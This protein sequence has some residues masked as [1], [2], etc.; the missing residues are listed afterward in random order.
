MDTFQHR[1]QNHL[2]LMFLGTEV[3]PPDAETTPD[4][5]IDD[6]LTPVLQLPPETLVAVVEMLRVL[7]LLYRVKALE[8]PD[9]LLL[10]EL[11]QMLDVVDADMTDAALTDAAG[12]TPRWRAAFAFALTLTF[13][14]EF[15]F[16]FAFAF[17][18]YK[19]DPDADDPEPYELF[20]FEWA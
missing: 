9:A 20:A 14:F 8:L 1:I 3:Y 19:P 7:E 2:L 5:A 6:G 18:A 15:A 10:I 17:G 16:A 11:R 12:D 4:D 13:E